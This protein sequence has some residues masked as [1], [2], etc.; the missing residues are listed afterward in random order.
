[1]SHCI[2]LDKENTKFTKVFSDLKDYCLN[3]INKETILVKLEKHKEF[4]E[5]P[6]KEVEGETIL[7]K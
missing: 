6:T 1:M 2:K 4:W 3:K 5:D 7:L